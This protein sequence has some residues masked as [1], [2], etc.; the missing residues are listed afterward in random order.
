MFGWHY[1]LNGH[2]FEQALGDHEGQG[3]L[4]CGS[5]QGRKE[6]D[7]TERLN[8]NISHDGRMLFPSKK[9]AVSLNVLKNILKMTA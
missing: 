9:N 7:M 4:V 5:T 1:W 6:S 2:K 8:N 3:S